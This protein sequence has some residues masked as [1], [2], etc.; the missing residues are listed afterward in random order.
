[1]CVDCIWKRV[2]YNAGLRELENRIK[3]TRSLQ[4][5]IAFSRQNIRG[6]IYFHKS[7]VLWRQ[8]LLKYSFGRLCAE[9]N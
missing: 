3:H 1:M 5:H 8:S 2:C 9:E 6:N 4:K 7:K